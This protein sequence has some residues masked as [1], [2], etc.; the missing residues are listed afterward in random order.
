MKG[1]TEKQRLIIEFIEDF[2]ESESIPPTIYE[3]AEHFKISASTVSIHLKTLSKK[4]FIQRSEKA[5]TISISPKYSK[6]RRRPKPLVK[7]VPLLKDLSLIE[8]I[9]NGDFFPENY[10]TIDK[11]LFSTSADNFI[12]AIKMPDSSLANAGINNGDIIFFK[13][14][15]ETEDGTIAAILANG[16]T[17]VRIYNHI[18]NDLIELR[19]AGKTPRS[20]TFSKKESKIY[21]IPC[22]II[23]NIS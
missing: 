22:L 16:K 4:G 1:L 17:Y 8:S 6:F 3:I 19:E 12:F 5:R 9:K 21:G 10:L 2:T 20:A 23:K 15:T 7:I 13:E 14:V 11:S 18:D